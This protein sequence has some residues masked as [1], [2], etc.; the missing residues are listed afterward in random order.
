MDYLSIVAS[1]IEEDFWNWSAARNGLIAASI[2][3]DEERCMFFWRAM[4]TAHH[5][6][7]DPY[8]RPMRELPAIAEEPDLEWF[9]EHVLDA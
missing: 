9:N 4:Q 8:F 5:Q 1:V 6:F 2:L 3:Q 7:H